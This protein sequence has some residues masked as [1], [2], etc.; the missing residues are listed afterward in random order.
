MKLL[1]YA[2]RQA[3]AIA[4]SRRLMRYK[5]SDL[6]RLE[7]KVL[8][9]YHSESGKKYYLT[10][11]EMNRWEDMARRDSFL[12][13]CRK[14]EIIMDLGC[15]AG[16]LAVGLASHFPGKQVLAVDT[17]EHAG[18]LIAESALPNLR[19]QKA[20]VLN[21]GSPPDSVDMVISSF[22]IEHLVYPE[23]M[24]AEAHRIL[25]PGGIFYLVYPHLLL[26]VG[27]GTFFLEVV[28]WI[29]P[30]RRLIYLEPQIGE[31]TFRGDDQDAVWVANHVKIGRMLRANGFSVIRSQLSQSLVIAEKH[32]P[33]NNVNKSG[34]FNT[35]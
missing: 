34:F 6:A 8:A 5:G 22:V 19:F 26:K 11:A 1:L 27:L 14:A 21:S 17:G 15:G 23:R 13:I 16:S 25:R 4:R 31:E 12:E 30:S 24:L 33:R 3:V 28:S 29:F 35:T 9:F 32:W 10:L 7:Q 18:Q 20:S 2:L